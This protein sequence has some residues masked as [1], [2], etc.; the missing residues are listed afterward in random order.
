MTKVEFYVFLFVVLF[1]SFKM[2]QLVYDLLEGKQKLK[3]R[4]DKSIYWTIWGLKCKEILSLMCYY[5]LYVN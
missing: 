1:A 4:F 5:A 3:F 2:D